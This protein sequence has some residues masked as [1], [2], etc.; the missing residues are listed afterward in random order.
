MAVVTDPR[1]R[2]DADGNADGIVVQGWGSRPNW[3][4]YA[5]LLLTSTALITLEISL[6]RFFSHTI[7]YHFAYL[8]ISVALL[9]F[10]AAGSI[11]AAFPALLVRRGQRFLVA[12]LVLAALVTVAGLA[13]LAQFPIQVEKLTSDPLHFSMT[14]LVYYVIVG[15]PFLLA[16]FSIS[17]PFAAWPQR[18]GRLYF[19]DLLGAALGCAVV[20]IFIEMLGVPGLIFAAAGLMLLAASALCLAG[21]MR[22][23]GWVL[24]ALA[25]GV[26]VFAGPAGSRLPVQVTGS[27]TLAGTER[28]LETM[29]PDGPPLSERTDRFGKWTAINRVDAFGWDYPLPFAFWTKLGLSSNW[30]WSEYRPM[31][32]TLTY[33]GGNGSDLY[34]SS[35]DLAREFEFL[36]HHQLRLPYVV[37]DKPNV[38]VIGVGGGIDLFNAIKQGARHVTGVELQPETVRLLK[39]RLRDFN[40][41]FFLRDDVTLVAGEG[42]HFVR[43]TD[44][45]FD[46]VQITAVDTFAAQA[47]GAYVLAESYLY[48]VEALQD[49]FERLSP[50][51][52]V[53][54][55]VGDLPYPG[56][57]PPLATRLA[58]IG[59]RALQRDGASDPGLH[60]M[61]TNFV[62]KGE[63][64]E[65]AVV[66]VKKSPFTKDEIDRVTA[67]NDR[68]GFTTLYAP[69][70]AG[71]RLASILSADEK[72]RGTALEAEMFDVE[73]TYDNDPFFYNVSKWKHFSPANYTYF[74]MPGSFM[75]QLVLVLMVLQSTLLGSVLVIVPLLLGARGGLR[76]PGVLSYL[77]YF[78][79]LGLGFMF[80]EISFVQ[81]FVLFLGSPTYAL[82]VTI[83]A[84]LLFSGIGSLLSTRFAAYPEAALQRLAP[85]VAGLIVVYAY[86]LSSVFDAALHLDIGPR[87]VIAMLAQMPIGLVLGMFMPLGVACIAR[88]NARLVPWA[89]GVNGVGSVAGTTLAVLLAMAVGFRTVSLIAAALYLI[90]TALL[91]RASRSART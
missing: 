47:V 62:A 61:V 74:I 1:N 6:T 38:L 63:V 30:N 8:T 48:T 7:W 60:I 32:A 69:G 89:W 10:G 67:F 11:V 53:S 82:S 71:S 64:S 20:G 83:F 87:I 52:M 54:M 19:W 37:L 5:A 21:G 80:V 42:R 29:L 73:A 17:V 15:A 66:L 34:R 22:A 41:G 25:T 58:S 84:L 77:A 2:S 76:G 65:N 86:G 70:M 56:Q 12:S 18:M 57:A 26:L 24:A 75:G 59:Y 4:V 36:E 16:G 40:G 3:G 49:Y 55:V 23:G 33:D 72:V 39:D 13:F 9:G 27:K 46:L 51:G 31:V 85:M 43:K 78:L 88:E 45:V 44:Q 90:G 79:A 50:D 91:L 14:L 81:S 28:V 35:G 68:E